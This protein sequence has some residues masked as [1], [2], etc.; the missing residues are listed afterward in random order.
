ME[1]YLWWKTTFD[2]SL[3]LIKDNLWWKTTNNRRGQLKTPFD[4]R[5]PL[6]KDDL[7]WK[8]TLDGRRPLME[9]HL[10]WKT[11]FDGRRPSI[12]YRTENQ[13]TKLELDTEEQILL[14]C[15]FIIWCDTWSENESSTLI[16]KIGIHLHLKELPL[17]FP[18]DQNHFVFNTNT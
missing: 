9:D 13:D 6:V 18:W 17:F 15:Y 12:K 8:T 3:P 16:R 5:W 4:G 11:T 1:D 10:R 7:W 14:S 2:K